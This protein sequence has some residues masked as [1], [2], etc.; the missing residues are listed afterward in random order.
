MYPSGAA[1]GIVLT[2]ELA[3]FIDV[4]RPLLLRGQNLKYAQIKKSG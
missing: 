3:K 1:S 4:R 2:E